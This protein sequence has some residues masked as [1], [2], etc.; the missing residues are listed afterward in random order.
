MLR[1]KTAMGIQN[2]WNQQSSVRD[3]IDNS[4][5]IYEIGKTH[6]LFY[7]KLI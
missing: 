5:G 4:W 3:G 7:Q 1:R 2:V 6:E